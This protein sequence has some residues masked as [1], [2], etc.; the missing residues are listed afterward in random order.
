MI[1]ERMNIGIF[2]ILL[3]KAVLEMI[4]SNNIGQI[5]S[6]FLSRSSAL[7][8]IDEIRDFCVRVNLWLKELSRVKMVQ[9]CKISY[10]SQTS[11]SPRVVFMELLD[12][13]LCNYWN[14]ISKRIKYLWFCWFNYWTSTPMFLKVNRRFETYLAKHEDRCRNNLAIIR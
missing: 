11:S 2:G 8:F 9:I 12:L 5:V 4:V 1:D 10:S 6:D 13:M 7:I 14:I 3:K